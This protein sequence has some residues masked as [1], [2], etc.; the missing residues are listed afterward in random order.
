MAGE[1]PLLVYVMTRSSDWESGPMAPVPRQAR[2]LP[3]VAPEANAC[4]S[5]T[6]P[7]SSAGHENRAEVGIRG[8]N[9]REVV[10]AWGPRPSNQVSCRYHHPVTP[11]PPPTP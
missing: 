2:A 10:R 1:L 8:D 5:T 3:A 7:S 6:D 11:P 4:L 9:A